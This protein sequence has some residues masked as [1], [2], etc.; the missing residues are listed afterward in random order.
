[1]A[2]PPR[3]R[4]SREDRMEQMLDTAHELF[5]DR[6]YAAVTMDEI[7]TAAGITKPLIY[8]YFGSKE[9]LFASCL[10]HA[11]ELIAEAAVAMNFGAS[12]E[13]IARCCHAHPTLAEALKEAALAV[14][15]RAINF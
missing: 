7:A 12:S 10:A 15:G 2:N 5:A 6:G 4:L 3:T 9:G 11:G 13:D 14:D 1:M 8:N